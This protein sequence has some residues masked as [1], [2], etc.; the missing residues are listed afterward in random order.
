MSPLRPLAGKRVV[1]FS[2]LLPGPFTSLLLA[3]LGAEVIKVEEPGTGD[4]ARWYPPM[5]GDSSGAFAALNRDKKSIAVQLKSPEGLALAK[6]LALGADVVLESFRPGVMARLGLGWEALRAENPRLIYCA[7]SG[8]GQTGPYRERA[9]HDINYAALSGA[10]ALNG[11]AGREPV[12]MGIQLGDLGGGAL[13]A[14][15]GVVSAVLERERTGEGR[16]LDVSMTDGA[17]SF[18]TM[19]LGK[20]A[21]GA[22]NARRGEDELAGGLP[23]YG[24]YATKDGGAMALGALEPKFWQGF[25]AAVERPDLL[26]VGHL[27]GEAGDEARR[28]LAALFATRTRDEWTTLF[29]QHDVCCEP[30]L[31]PA[32]LAGHALHQARGAFATVGTLALPRTPL[33]PERTGHDGSAASTPAPGLG[34]DTREILRD[35][36][37]ADADIDGLAARGVV[38]LG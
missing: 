18:L 14:A 26:G 9:G 13:Y 33:S 31:E 2:R 21:A 16:Y 12:V 25:C 15:L 27:I 3:E 34:A 17:L 37:Y 30:V 6:R 10:L 29:A 32:E 19:L 20:V 35:L 22:T 8:Y 5:A 38:A 23:C 28:A 4:Y 24:V 11:Y 7:I 36:G 1:D